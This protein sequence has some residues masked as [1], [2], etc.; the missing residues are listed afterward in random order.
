[1]KRYIS[2]TKVRYS[3]LFKKQDGKNVCVEFRGSMLTYTTSDRELQA[4]I[5]GTAYF[6]RNQIAIDF[7]S[8]EGAA[9]EVA[10]Q[11]RNDGGNDGDNNGT[12]EP[13]E[14][15]PLQILDI[16]DIQGAIDYLKKEFKVA[17]SKLKTPSQVKNAMK[18]HKVEFP[19]LA[20]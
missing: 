19:N 4:L 8:G 11:A 20:L 18:E 16:T 12:G 7:E 3:I 13:I 6:K 1:M 2:K 14:E 5:E 10:G 15:S 9:G 17:D